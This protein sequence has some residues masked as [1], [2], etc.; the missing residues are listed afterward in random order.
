MKE[1]SKKQIFEKELLKKILKIRPEFQLMDR[2]YYARPKWQKFTNSSLK[3]AKEL[4][5]KFWLNFW[6]LYHS[7]EDNGIDYC[8]IW[9]IALTGSF[10]EH[11]AGQGITLAE[12]NLSVYIIDDSKMKDLRDDKIYEYE[13]TKEKC[14]KFI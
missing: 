5:K 13:L 4:D 6:P 9:E 7:M 2:Y 14:I 3:N 8:K 10:K 12:S 1:L 11:W